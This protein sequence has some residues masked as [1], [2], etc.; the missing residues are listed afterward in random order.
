MRTGMEMQIKPV[1]AVYDRRGGR[2][3]KKRRSQ[4]AA[5]KT[6]TFLATAQAANHANYADKE[7]LFV[8]RSCIW[9]AVAKRR[10]E[11]SQT[12]KCLVGW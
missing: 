6:Q 9:R 4:S 1:T 5:T 3:G 8:L 2:N 12:R 11:I 7:K 10:W